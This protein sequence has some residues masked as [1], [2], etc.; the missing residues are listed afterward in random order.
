MKKAMILLAMALLLLTG[1]NGARAQRPLIMAGS[2]DYMFTPPPTQPSVEVYPP[3]EHGVLAAGLD[4][5]GN[6]YR[7]KGEVT[8]YGVALVERLMTT[9][10]Y[11]WVYL[12]QDRLVDSAN[13][14]Y[15]QDTIAKELFC[16]IEQQ[17]VSYADFG[18]V[19]TGNNPNGDTT[20]MP[21]HEF[22]FTDP[23]QVPAGV[24]FYVGI[25]HSAYNV[26]NHW[27]PG[28]PYFTRLFFCEPTFLSYESYANN[29]DSSCRFD[30]LD[31]T[32]F[33]NKLNFP[34]LIDWRCDR[35]HTP[36]ATLDD[37]LNNTVRKYTARGFFPIVRPP[38]DSARIFPPHEHPL[39]AGAVTGFRVA[40]LDSAHA[41][42]EW[43]TLEPSDWGLVGVNAEAY[44]VSYAP[45]GEEYAEGDTLMSRGGSCTLRTAFDSTVMYKARCRVLSYHDCDIHDTM[46]W[47]EWSE[48]VYFHTGV[49]VPDTGVLECCHVEG[50]RYLGLSA[51]KPRFSWEGCEGADRYELQYATIGGDGWRRGPV[52]TMEGCVLNAPLDSTHRYMARVRSQC[53]HHCHVHD[54]VVQGAWSDTVEFSLWTGGIGAEDGAVGRAMFGLM[55]N[56]ARGSAT[57]RPL[58]SGGEYPA[59]LTV[60]DAAGR[61]VL[62]RQLLDGSPQTIELGEMPSG[63]YFVTLTTAKDTGTQKLIIN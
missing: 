29:Q 15:A 26:Y 14:C 23:V 45:Y 59:V 42:F 12:L 17:P 20:T 56:P 31:S 51:G 9:Y 61:E 32:W 27:K 58:L 19:A 11:L 4:F 8:V 21:F 40:E 25:S 50:F 3:P 44:Q 47:G 46:V 60:S 62:R 36:M 43:D 7:S 48:E 24:R 6:A 13:L 53:D 37:E 30:G 57:V 28:N 18:F 16:F 2:P 55:P 41:T 33:L 22:Y 49:G 1:T 52:S 63:T 38:E 34:G 39:R 54:T 35:C 10:P 5:R